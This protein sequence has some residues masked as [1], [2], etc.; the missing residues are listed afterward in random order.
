MAARANKRDTKTNNKSSNQSRFILIRI[1]WT[2]LPFVVCVC[3]G[4]GKR[5]SFDDDDYYLFIFFN[6]FKSTE[7]DSLAGFLFVWWKVSQFCLFSQHLSTYSIVTDEDR[8]HR[9]SL[10]L[11]WLLFFSSPVRP[12]VFF[13]LL[14]TLLVLYILRY[15]NTFIFSN[16]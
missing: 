1:K 11:F 8:T 5:I 2:C 16:K 7:F 14:F 10:C 6:K 15:T 3:R 9:H 12:D 13:I 4:K